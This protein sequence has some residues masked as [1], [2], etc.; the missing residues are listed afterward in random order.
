LLTTIYLFNLGDGNDTITDVGDTATQYTDKIIF[1]ADVSKDDLA[2]FMSGTDLA[3]DYGT[4]I[5][6][7]KIVV[8]GQASS[9]TAIE[10][11]QLSDGTYISNTDVNQLIQT[12]TAYALGHGIQMTS[13]N[14]VKN[15]QDLMNLVAGS[16]HS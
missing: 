10:K 6:Q 13:V 5:G 8:L 1:G 16:F 3:I 9:S 15:N 4:I 12:M 14:D 2:V 7:D 11:I